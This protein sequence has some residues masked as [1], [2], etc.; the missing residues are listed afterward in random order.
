[1]LQTENIPNGNRIL[2]IVGLLVLLIAIQPIAVSAQNSAR[3]ERGPQ[4]FGQCVACHT[5]RQEQPHRFGPNLFGIFDRGIAGAEG[6]DYGPV[7]QSMQGQKWTFTLMNRFVAKPHLA[8][9]GSNMK[10]K[11]MMNPHDRA[12]LLAWLE[13]ASRDP[14]LPESIDASI[15][16]VGEGNPLRGS[17]L[18]R[19]CKACHSFT[20]NAPH[21]IG[22]NLFGV[23]GRQV[24]SAEGFSYSQN[25]LRRGG[26]WSSDTL[27]VFFVEYKT[28]TQGTH[29]A[30]R[31]LPDEQD[32]LDI[33]AWLATLSPEESRDAAD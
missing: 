7:L 26:F 31:A 13:V 8:L 24:A 2:A 30:F 20:E 5:L 18:F 22:P 10:F 11:G 23:V 25:L 3:P 28:F 6:Y 12:D 14:D 9:P 1:M 21:K 16:M 32:R 17:Q 19:P 29:A 15:Y 27:N 33:I 4:L